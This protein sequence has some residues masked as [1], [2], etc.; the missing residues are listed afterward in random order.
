MIVRV[1]EMVMAVIVLGESQG[2]GDHCAAAHRDHGDGSE[3]DEDD[4]IAAGD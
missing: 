4:L 2:D 3:N 1:K